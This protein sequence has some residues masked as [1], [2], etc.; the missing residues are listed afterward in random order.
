MSQP[1]EETK[2]QIEARKFA[3][4]HFDL[5]A[6]HRLEMFRSYVALLGLTYAGFG[7][8]LQLK[9]YFIC[10]ALSVFAAILSMIFFLFD[11]RIRL[12]LKISE[13]Y[14]LDAEK[15]LSVLLANPNIRLF[16]KSDLITQVNVRCFRLTYSN[17]FCIIYFGNVLVALASLAGLIVYASL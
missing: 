11:M 13:R 15:Q 8:A 12:L 10:A 9:A 6:G 3:W 2:V 14:L 16:R 7:A 4:D 5:H 17:L 1:E